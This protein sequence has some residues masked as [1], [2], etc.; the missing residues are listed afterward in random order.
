MN[1]LK[2]KTRSVIRFYL[3][4]QKRKYIEW[5]QQNKKCTYCKKY[6]PYYFVTWDHV[7]AKSIWNST[8]V[9]VCCQECNEKKADKSLREFYEEKNEE[10][11]T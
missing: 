1:N 2:Q 5:L 3:G 6:T 7:Y 4:K 11:E 8:Y 10:K 9:V